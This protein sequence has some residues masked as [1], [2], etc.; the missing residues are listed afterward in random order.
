MRLAAKVDANQKQIVDAARK[1]GASVQSLAV[2]GKGVPDLLIGIHGNNLLVE[3]KDGSRIKSQRQLTPDQM[4]WH[5]DWKGQKIVINNVS[6]L[7]ELLNSISGSQ[8]V[9][10]EV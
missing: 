6:E 5:E 10:W 1:M 8:H 4:K 9:V 2:I 3:V 7:K